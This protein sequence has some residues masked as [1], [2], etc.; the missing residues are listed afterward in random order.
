MSIE[1]VQNRPWTDQ[2]I[3]DAHNMTREEFL[4]TYPDR[5]ANALRFKKKRTLDAVTVGGGAS[6]GTIEVQRPATTEEWEALFSALE[7][8]SPEREGLG[9]TQERTT[10]TSHDNR[11][12]GIA[13]VGD[14]HAGNDGVMYK[15][16]KSD[17]Q[18]IRD[19]EGLF[20]VGMGDYM[21][22]FKPQAKSG[23]GMYHALFA[24][25]VEQLQFITMRLEI[26]KGKW[27]ALAQGNHDAWDFKWAGIDR[28]PAL[29]QHLE[30]AYFS[31]RGGTVKVLLGDQTYNIVVKHDYRGKSQI[32]KSNSQR[33][34]FDDYPEWGNADVICL[35]HLHE[36][37]TEQV[38]RRGRTVTYLRSGTYKIH[39]PWAE[40]AGYTPT[41]GVP[42]V[43][44]YPETRK[45]VAFHG[46]HFEEAVAFLNAIRN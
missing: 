41:Y 42:V 8:V 29:A 33:R 44:L 31:E 35:A 20:A 28:L 10:F 27:L 34:M 4:S 5:T 2:E 45:I 39:D 14:I 15:R 25:P 30:T 1:T 37:L 32:N 17:M 24:D 21:D 19:T 3:T 13:F 40:A 6:D 16:F 12:I 18:R 22:N 7:D 38:L 46:E 43:V 36:P 11:P 26:A 23:T 9:L